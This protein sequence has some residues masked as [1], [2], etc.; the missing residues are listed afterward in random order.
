LAA[1]EEAA[2]VTAMNK[3]KSG[4]RFIMRTLD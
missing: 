1:W 4:M 2:I 3:A